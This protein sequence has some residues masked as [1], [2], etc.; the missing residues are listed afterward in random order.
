VVDPA[1]TEAISKSSTGDAHN[2]ISP[3]VACYV[4]RITVNP[5]PANVEYR[6]SY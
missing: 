4:S 2:S 3:T 1:K 6:V 5:Y